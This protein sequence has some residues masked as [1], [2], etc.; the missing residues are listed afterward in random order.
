MNKE[1]SL[2]S[3]AQALDT[4]EQCRYDPLPGF[5]ASETTGFY[6]MLAVCLALSTP[7]PPPAPQFCLWALEEWQTSLEWLR[8]RNLP[9]EA[10]NYKAG[11]GSRLTGLNS[12]IRSHAS[13]MKKTCHLLKPK[14]YPYMLFLIF[15]C[16]KL[17]SSWQNKWLSPVPG[18]I[19]VWP[20]CSWVWRRQA[21]LL[22]QI[23][24]I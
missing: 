19:M 7:P 23:A 10:S 11:F 14:S 8:Q 24:F 9:E 21:M 4:S 13:H 22:A 17:H 18:H 1:S 5:P 12:G 6:W 3:L 2:G 20:L 15:W 16:G